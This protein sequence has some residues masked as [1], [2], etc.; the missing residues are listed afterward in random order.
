M[1]ANDKVL[2]ASKRLGHFSNFRFRNAKLSYY[3][4]RNVAIYAFSLGKFLNVTVNACVKDLTNI[5]SESPYH[6][7]FGA[8]FCY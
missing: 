8:L 5:M 3:R 6:N 7:N 4:T 1:Q 2:T